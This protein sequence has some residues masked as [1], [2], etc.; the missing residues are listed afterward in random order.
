MIK[1]IVIAVAFFLFGTTW[2]VEW[3]RPYYEA[4][5]YVTVEQR[6]LHIEFEYVWN[7]FGH[8][9]RREWRIYRKE[10]PH[11]NRTPDHPG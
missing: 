11:Y 3:D 8:R 9:P 4:P 10:R 6:L 7:D 5:G 1:L 2:N